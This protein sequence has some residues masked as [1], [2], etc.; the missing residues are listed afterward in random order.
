MSSRASGRFVR[1]TLVAGA[2]AL[3]QAASAGEVILNHDEWTLTDYGFAQAPAS[4]TTY[5]QNLAAALNSN[6]GACNLLVHSNNFGLTGSSLQA[7]LIAS[8]CSV[9]YSLGAMN[10]GTLSG[11]DGVLLAGSQTGYDAGVLASYVNAG[12]N[13][14][15]AGGTGTPNEDTIW[16][17]F[18]HQFGLDF[19]PSYNG[20][21]GLL[22]ISSSY[23]LFGGVSELYF[24][25]G[26][27][28]STYGN[29]PDAQVVVTYGDDGLFG[30]YDGALPQ[31]NPTAVVPEP[32]TLALL[33]MGV[34]VLG[35]LRRR[36]R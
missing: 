27:S 32:A 34:G 5:A 28:V 31:T 18:T 11:Y 6:G 1:A 19:G 23:P 9:T 10:S 2:L 36:A 20:I 30:V 25:N 16:D 21:E 13:V 14:Y 17:S 26:N 8:G 15:I 22:P 7:V 3:A 12:G 4:T 35:F 33:G 29:N 24:N